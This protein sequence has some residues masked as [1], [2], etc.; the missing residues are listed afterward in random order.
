[1]RLTTKAQYSITVV[2]SFRLKGTI[3]NIRCMDKIEITPSTAFLTGQALKTVCQWSNILK[4]FQQR[5]SPYQGYFIL[6]ICLRNS[7]PKEQCL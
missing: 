2:D 1:M 7:R 4:S 3:Q 6:K 5:L